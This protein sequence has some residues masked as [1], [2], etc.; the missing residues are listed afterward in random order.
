MYLIQKDSNLAVNASETIQLIAA[1][2]TKMNFLIRRK[3][4]DVEHENIE[5]IEIHK[6]LSS[7]HVN[8][9]LNFEN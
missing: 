3:W 2:K 8:F 1:D 7:L 5:K 9:D 4:A 6:I